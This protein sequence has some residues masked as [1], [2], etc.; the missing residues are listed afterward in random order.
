M[1]LLDAQQILAADDKHI[2]KVA[3]PEW[4]KDAK[5]LVGTMGALDRARLD[6]W[7]NSLGKSPDPPSSETASGSEDAEP[8]DLVTCDSPPP[9]DEPQSVESGQ[10]SQA[11]TAA[12][13]YTSEDNTAVMVRWCALCILDPKTRKRAFTDDQVEALGAKSPAALLRVYQAALGVNL[14]TK[15]AAEGFEKNSAGTGGGD[16][17]GD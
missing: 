5:V 3:V 12:K 7:I 8:E 11:A 6:D 13:E 10:D 17:G 14:A 15:A 2:R 4:G 9:A 16:S 1:P